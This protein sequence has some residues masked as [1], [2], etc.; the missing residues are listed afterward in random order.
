MY[1]LYNPILVGGDVKPSIVSVSPIHMRYVEQPVYFSSKRIN[2]RGGRLN[3]IPITSASEIYDFINKHFDLP[4]TKEELERK[5]M[6][7]KKNIKSIDKKVVDDLKNKYFLKANKLKETILLLLKKNKKDVSFSE[8]DKHFTEIEEFLIDYSQDLQNKFLDKPSMKG[9]ALR[10]YMGEERECPICGDNIR[11]NE[12]FIITHSDERSHPDPFHYDCI[13]KSINSI[14]YGN[15]CPICREPMT[16]ADLRLPESIVQRT[17]RRINEM[18][19]NIR[20][21]LMFILC[22]I[23]VLLPLSYMMYQGLP[24]SLMCIVL[25]VL[26][27]LITIIRFSMFWSG[28]IP[29]TNEVPLFHLTRGFCMDIPGIAQTGGAGS[30]DIDQ[31]ILEAEEKMRVLEIELQRLQNTRKKIMFADCIEGDCSD[32]GPNYVCGPNNICQQ[33]RDLPM[34]SKSVAERK[35]I[36]SRMEL[37]MDDELEEI[38][39]QIAEMNQQ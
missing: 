28:D 20:D 5:T 31:Q 7:L 15:K 36:V 17:M 23:V 16:E 37:Q 18:F 12:G 6:S 19:D 30:Q 3:K 29:S 4:F 14:R 39:K 27:L 22:L 11:P 34:D 21:P 10:P 9:G 1:K 2:K 8:L 32:L 38:K 35:K 33:V 13:S 24:T 26:D 25:L